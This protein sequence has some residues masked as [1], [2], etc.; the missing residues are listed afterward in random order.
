VTG[1]ILDEDGDLA[2]LD[3]EI[4][5][6]LGRDERSFALASAAAE[7][8]R[9]KNKLGI[10]IG[11]AALFLTVAAGA[12]STDPATSSSGIRLQPSAQVDRSTTK[13][14]ELIQYQ[15]ATLRLRQISKLTPPNQVWQ[16]GEVAVSSA[17]QIQ[18]QE[19]R[20]IVQQAAAHRLAVELKQ[21]A[22]VALAEFQK[23]QLLEGDLRQAREEAA[24]HRLSFAE[25]ER[26]T[27]E[28]GAHWQ[29][30]KH[31]LEENIARLQQRTEEMALTIEHQEEEQRTQLALK[32]LNKELVRH[33]SQME[34][35]SL[36]ARPTV[37]LHTKK[38]RSA[39]VP[40]EPASATS[41]VPSDKEN[42]K[43]KKTNFS[44][45]ASENRDLDE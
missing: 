34:T 27:R 22:D 5:D 36:V 8:P 21:R 23:A 25:L 35:R 33:T 12:E 15:S 2:G 32:E 43:Q 16:P 20:R 26:Q 39:V 18:A 44:R 38:T 1:E 19:L 31:K 24:R 29:V 28:T 3:I 4:N 10:F 11:I 9:R 41:M 13:Q 30:E 42:K 17:G 14:A 37:A 45:Y 6:L 7:K 40:G